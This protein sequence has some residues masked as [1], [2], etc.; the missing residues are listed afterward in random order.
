MQDGHADI[1]ANGFSSCGVVLSSQ[2]EVIDI[3]PIMERKP[4]H[5]ARELAVVVVAA[6]MLDEHLLERFVVGNEDVAG[7]TSADE[8][9]YLFGQILGMVA[10]ALQRLRHKDDLQ[11]GL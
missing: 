10:S 2:P 8:V 6:E 3:S 4:D 1:Q 7:G 5:K 9:A 11:A